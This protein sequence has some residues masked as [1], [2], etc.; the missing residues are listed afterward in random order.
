MSKVNQQRLSCF[1]EAGH[2]VQAWIEGIPILKLR[3]VP[4]TEEGP[5]NATI[6]TEVPGNKPEDWQIADIVAYMRMTLAAPEAEKLA[7]MPNRAI[8]RGYQKAEAHEHMLQALQFGKQLGGGRLDKNGIVNLVAG[9]EVD[10]NEVFQKGFVIRCVEALASELFRHKTLLGSDVEA[11]IGHR[12][13][14]DQRTVLQRECCLTALC[15]D[16]HDRMPVWLGRERV[17]Q[18][19]PKSGASRSRGVLR[20]RFC[21]TNRQVM[22]ISHCI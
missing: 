4:E 22:Y 20:R 16:V 5:F 1:H 19:H 8:E 10:V 14:N 18:V 13:S 21:A 12:I 3:L 2:A 7:P 17:G 11:F 15:A 6:A 9:S